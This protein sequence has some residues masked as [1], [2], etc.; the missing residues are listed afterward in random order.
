[1]RILAG[2]C[3]ASLAL[4]ACDR[5][6][7]KP[8]EP[9]QG[10][11]PQAEAPKGPPPPGVKAAPAVK[12]GLWEITSRTP[13]LEGKVR[14]CFDPGIQGESA[15]VAQG[16]DRRNCSRS[17]WTKTPDGYAFDVACERNG[18]MFVSSGTLSGDLTTRYTIK[19]DAV[20]SVG[21]MQH[22]AKQ[23]IEAKNIGECPAG[24]RAGE[25]MVLRDGKWSRAAAAPG[26]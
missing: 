17:D 18:R 12:G 15:V 24:M 4:V 14:S 6:V 8:V 22:G 25:A 11:R 23:D 1:M 10:S 7:E 21:E 5:T 19:A 16:M 26:G 13:G 2:V 20:M 9:E 3:L